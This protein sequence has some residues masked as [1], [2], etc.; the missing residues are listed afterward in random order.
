[1]GVSSAKAQFHLPREG[2]EFQSEILLPPPP[3]FSIPEFEEP[4]E[5]HFQRLFKL[6]QRIFSICH[7]D[8][9]YYTKTNIMPPTSASHYSSDE[10]ALFRKKLEFCLS[11]YTPGFYIAS[12]NWGGTIY[13]TITSDE[14]KAENAR[15]W[16]YIEKNPGEKMHLC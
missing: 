7:F 14:E 13:F 2:E 1:M 11:N 3:S 12:V 8:P 10:Q 5:V 9:F 4:F 6:G 16:S 15:I